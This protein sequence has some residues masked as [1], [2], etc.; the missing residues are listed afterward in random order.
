MG[1]SADPNISGKIAQSFQSYCFNLEIKNSATKKR[2]AEM[3]AK[4]KNPWKSRL[5]NPTL[6]A[7]DDKLDGM[8]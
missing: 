1:L 5:K 7:K 3:R 2:L 4:V 6:T 8:H